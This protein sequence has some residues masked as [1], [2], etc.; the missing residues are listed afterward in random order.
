MTAPLPRLAR[1][2]WDDIESAAIWCS[3]TEVLAIKP[4]KCITVGWILKDEPYLLIA[5]T[6]GEDGSDEEWSEIVAIP[7]GCV[8]KVEDLG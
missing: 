4:S 7:K 1:V 5:A 2:E 6:R 8:L 3:H